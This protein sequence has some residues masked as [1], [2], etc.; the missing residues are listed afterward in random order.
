MPMPR[1]LRAV[2]LLL[3]VVLPFACGDGGT[4]STPP[5]TPTNGSNGASPAPTTA[6]VSMLSTGDGYGSTTHS[7]DPSTVTIR[8][9]GTVTWVNESGEVHNVT[10]AAVE[11]APPHIADNDSGSAE[12]TFS[13]TGT[14]N[15]DCTNHPGMTGSVVVQSAD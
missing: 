10:F 13:A 11:G 5:A 14:F 15:Y 12:R 8:A 2:A 9:D 4:T 7:F 1:L 3:V 6:N